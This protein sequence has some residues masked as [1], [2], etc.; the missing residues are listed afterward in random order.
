MVGVVGLSIISE[1]LH[2]FLPSSIVH[3]EH[4]DGREHIHHPDHAES[5][6]SECE[7]DD[8]D[9]HGHQ[10]S[11]QSEQGGHGTHRPNS[12]RTST[13]GE[14]VVAASEGT[15]LLGRNPS[16]RRSSFK[17]RL[18]G[19]VSSLV[20]GKKGACV[21][22]G[23]CYGYSES[24]PCDRMCQPHIKSVRKTRSLPCSENGHATDEVH[25]NGAGYIRGGVLENGHAAHHHDS[26]LARPRPTTS[27]HSHD[28]SGHHHVPKNEFLSIG[29]QTSK[30]FSSNYICVCVSEANN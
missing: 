12:Q 24:R 1:I 27:V 30:F 26:P 10:H 3:C 25:S 4:S 7:E 17:A 13:D 19:S 6:E 15:P 20:V 21:G 28:H 14:T 23:T 8:E 18:S 16:S 11:H 29:L 22:D 9:T 2:H 5:D